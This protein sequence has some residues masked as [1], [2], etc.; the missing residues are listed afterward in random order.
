MGN[1]DKKEKNESPSQ[2]Y[3]YMAGLLSLT[4]INVVVYYGTS[5]SPAQLPKCSL[6]TVIQIAAM[7]I[8]NNS[9]YMLSHYLPKECSVPKE[10]VEV[11][12][13]DSIRD[14]VKKCEKLRAERKR[15]KRNTPLVTLF[16]TYAGHVHEDHEK[17]IVHNN[18]FINWSRMLPHVKLILFANKTYLK[19]TQTSKGWEIMS[20][21]RDDSSDERPPVLREMFQLAMQRFNTPWYAYV[22]ADI[23]FTDNFFNTLEE[24]SNTFDI[25]STRILVTGRRTNL[26]NVTKLDAQSSDRL[27]ERSRGVPKYREDAEDFF[28]TTKSFP[29]KQ[30]IPVVVG[31]P[32][33]DNWLVAAA[34]CEYNTTVIDVS[35]TVLAIHQTTQKGGNHEGYKHKA[36]LLNFDVIK[37]HNATANYI[38]GLTSCATYRSYKTLCGTIR[39]AKQEKLG[40]ACVCKKTKKT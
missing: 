17:F 4:V 14:L 29:W 35:K 12:L 28:I 37:K 10:K 2:M 5:H 26:E 30:I 34:R 16:T 8:S 13:A 1:R 27:E 40:P 22:N 19:E 6:E 21:S 18:T 33:Y 9:H 24:I 11:E 15:W 31:R 38:A 7:Y 20:S 32:G 25:K 3:M 36:S 23:L 39:F